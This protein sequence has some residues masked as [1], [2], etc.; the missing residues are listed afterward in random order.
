VIG[1][2]AKYNLLGE[3]GVEPNPK[4]FTRVPAWR[5]RIGSSVAYLF[6]IEPQ[7]L[8]QASYVAR[9]EVGNERHYQRILQK[10]RIRSIKRFLRKGRS[11]PNSIIVAFNKAPDFTPYPEVAKQYPWWPDQTGFGCLAFP[12]DYRSCWIIDGQHRLYGFSD[13]RTSANISVVAFHKLPLEKQAEYFIEINRE[14]KP[15]D[16]DLIWDLQGTIHPSSDDGVISNAVRKLNENPPLEKKI[17]IPL[18]GPKAKKQ[19]KF[20]GIC[21][22]VRKTRLTKETTISMT[23]TQKNPLHSRNH[24]RTVEK[25]SKAIAHFL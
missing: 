18:A 12:A 13:V 24:E 5:T 19:L 17:H 23:A 10:T 2:A 15:V 9:R 8:L 21:L 20:S 14:Q 1:S 22:T 6:F 11:F 25:V 3:M 7:K 16:P 4:S